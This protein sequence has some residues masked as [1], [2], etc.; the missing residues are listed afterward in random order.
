MS[1]EIPISFP[2]SLY[3]VVELLDH[4]VLAFVSWGICIMIPLMTVII[5]FP[6]LHILSSICYLLSF[7]QASLKG[8]RWCFT[9][10]LICIISW[11]VMLNTFS[12]ILWLFGCLLWRDVCVCPLLLLKLFLPLTFFVPMF[13]NVN[14][15]IRSII[16]K[17]FPRYFY[18]TGCFL[19]CAEDF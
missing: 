12:L 13:L 17:Y 16:R 6:I 11:F 5:L 2:L 9:V 3:V 8:V 19:C 10:V 15:L 1:A 14:P 7:W 18:L 4:I